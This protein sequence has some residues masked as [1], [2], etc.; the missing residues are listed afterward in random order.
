MAEKGDKTLKELIE[1]AKAGIDL[2]EIVDAINKGDTYKFLSKE[3]YDNLVELDSKTPSST[4]K[5]D[6]ESGGA[7][8][9]TTHP[10]QPP[11]TGYSPVHR[12]TFN[13]SVLQNTSSLPS[14][15]YVPKLPIFS[16]SEG[17]SKGEA[18]YDVEV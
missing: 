13:K 16:G 12:F 3:E 7:K 5:T 2:K 11:L 14:G 6:V 8:P 18:S 1:K 9:K 4:P 17:P 15:P 10:P